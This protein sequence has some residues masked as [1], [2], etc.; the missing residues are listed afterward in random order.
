MTAALNGK[1]VDAMVDEIVNQVIDSVTG[2]GE[3]VI[4][5]NHVAIAIDGPAGAGKTS[6]AK[7]LSS[8]LGYVYVDTGAM[9]RAFAVHKLWLAQENAAPVENEMAL[10][11]FDIEFTHDADGQ[12][13]I[14]W[15]KCID[16]YL[17][18]PEVSMESSNVSA[19]PAVRAALLDVQ[20]KQA[21]A[22]DVVMEGRDIGSV[23]LPDAE[24]KIYLTAEL[25]KRARRRYADLQAAGSDVK[26]GEV[27]SD[28]FIRDTQDMSREVAPLV[29]VEDAVLLDNSD[30][31]FEET[32]EAALKIIREK[33]A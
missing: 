3:E 15:G 6:L 19:D 8:K 1:S 31:T 20:R 10:N 25:A 30:L 16:E 14:L 18:T 27:S 9:Y 17:R 26:L 32:V 22:Y 4:K 33:L 13:T 21:Y 28:L 11:T 23:V 7:A 2:K 12:H 29:Q 5:R 24:V